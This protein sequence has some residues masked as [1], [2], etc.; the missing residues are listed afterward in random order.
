MQLLAWPVRPIEITPA[1]ISESIVKTTV[2]QLLTDRIM[3]M[4]NEILSRTSLSNIIQDPRLDLYKSDRASKPLEDVIEAMRKDIHIHIDSLPGDGFR[5]ASAF[6]IS[7]EYP[8]RVKAHDTVQALITKFQDENLTTQATQQKVVNTFVHDEVTE[9]RAKLD[10]L[11][12]ELTKFRINNSGRLPEQTSLNMAQLTSLQ[13]QST[14]INDGLN[15]LAQERV[16]L[17]THLQTL[18]GQLELF[19]MFDNEPALAAP[20]VKK[21]NELLVQLNKTIE[22]GETQLAQLRQS[23]SSKHPD[24][25]DMENRLQVLRNERDALQKKQD[26]DQAK[27]LEDAKQAPAKKTT[28][29]AAAQSLGQ[30]QGQIDSTKALI[31]AKEMERANLEKERLANKTQIDGYQAKLAATSGI[32][33]TYAEMI[34]NQRAA[35]E[36]YQI[37]QNQQQVTEQNSELLSRKAGEQLD[38]LDP[39]SLPTQPAKPKRWVIIGAGMAL[40]FV[41]GLAIAGIQEAKDT[42]LKNL[43]DVRAYTNLPVLSSIP[44]LENTM[45]VRRKRRIAYLAW[46]AGVIVGLLTVTASLYYH[47]TYS[48]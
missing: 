21:Q 43:K 30:V 35:Q 34:A 16:Q 29:F 13:Q 28:N 40:S 33:A 4:E 12:E 10:Q 47:Y 1:Q 18:Q 31:K 7:Y 46:S 8:D 11:N 27:L 38:V 32:E 25:R 19:D 3:Q 22:N 48:I 39:P 24:V 15:R 26:E 42:S 14:S 5:K 41:L 44:L 6:S 9:A 23:Y 17:D 2:N 45:L 36:K 20:V 37:L